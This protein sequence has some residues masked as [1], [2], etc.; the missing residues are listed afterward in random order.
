MSG[1][2]RKVKKPKR[3]LWSPAMR[4]AYSLQVRASRRMPSRSS[5]W[6]SSKPDELD[7]NA[8]AMPPASIASRLLPADHA[9]TEGLKP[10]ARAAVCAAI[11]SGGK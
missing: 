7:T 5:A 4:A 11:I 6:R 2:G 8:V 10:S 3:P 9:R 1:S